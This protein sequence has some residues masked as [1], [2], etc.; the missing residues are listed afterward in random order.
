MINLAM[1]NVEVLGL[2][3]SLIR[4][5]SSLVTAVVVGWFILA[6]ILDAR[7]N[8]KKLK[9]LFSQSKIPSAYCLPSR[10]FEKIREINSST[11]CLSKM[12]EL[13]DLHV[14]TLREYEKAYEV[15]ISSKRKS[16]TDDKFIQIHSGVVSAA[17]RLEAIVMVMEFLPR[18]HF[19]LEL[20]YRL[21]F[22]SVMLEIYE[23][24]K[25]ALEC[26][27]FYDKSNTDIA[28]VLAL[29]ENAMANLKDSQEPWPP[30]FWQ[31][32]LRA[33]NLLKVEKK[34]LPTA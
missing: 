3:G 15:L 10:F 18:F 6:L 1:L 2:F 20:A 34:E 30:K 4:A 9:E 27:E 13:R 28:Q 32:I 11:W 14:K 21:G 23:Q 31:S 19:Y 22:E 33:A 8:R 12:D 24:I 7:S 16:L 26:S 17:G 5:I 25:H 29:I